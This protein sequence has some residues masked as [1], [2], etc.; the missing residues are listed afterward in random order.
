MTNRRRGESQCS[1]D[2]NRGQSPSFHQPRPPTVAGLH[3]LRRGP[4]VRLLAHD[5]PGEALKLLA[6]PEAEIVF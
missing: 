4:K 2:H 6:R 3:R 5:L 1:R